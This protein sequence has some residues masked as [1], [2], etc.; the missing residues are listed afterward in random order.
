MKE[1]RLKDVF[2]WSTQFVRVFFA[3]HTVGLD[4]NLMPINNPLLQMQFFKC[5]QT[6]VIFLR[7]LFGL[8]EIVD[9]RHIENISSEIFRP[10]LGQ[11]SISANDEYVLKKSVLVSC[12]KDSILG[13]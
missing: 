7:I 2:R 4:T 11:Y 12:K 3:W 1:Q 10:Q 13:S 8:S 5:N 9:L 6:T